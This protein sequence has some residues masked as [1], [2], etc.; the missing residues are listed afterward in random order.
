MKDDDHFRHQKIIMKEIESIA[1]LADLEVEV[2]EAEE[3][4][5][6]GEGTTQM[7]EW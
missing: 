2:I 6:E 3:A 1:N 4:I 7:R 5:G